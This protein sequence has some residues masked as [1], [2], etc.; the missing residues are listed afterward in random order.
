MYHY[1]EGASPPEQHSIEGMNLLH[2]RLGAL[3]NYENVDVDI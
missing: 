1:F 2:P 3:I